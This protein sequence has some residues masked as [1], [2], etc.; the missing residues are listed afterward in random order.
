MFVEVGWGD[1]RETRC[2]GVVGEHVKRHEY[3][4]DLSDAWQCLGDARRPASTKQGTLFLPEIPRKRICPTTSPLASR[5]SA[6]KQN[7]M[8]FAELDTRGN[9]IGH[10][11]KSRISHVMYHTNVHQQDHPNPS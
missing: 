10:W 7:W 5:I 11:S 1:W 6:T 3:D 9:K 4:E 8:P 2:A